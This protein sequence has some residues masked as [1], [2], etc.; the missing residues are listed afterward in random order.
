[1]K[2]IIH[3]VLKRADV[4][5]LDPVDAGWAGFSFARGNPD[6]TE[7]GWRLH[8]FSPSN[9]RFDGP[10]VVQVAGPMGLAEKIREGPPCDHSCPRHPPV[11]PEGY[12][13]VG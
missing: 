10:D 4:S 8:Y 12:Q 7:A 1:M 13:V 11:G 9:E 3:H 6:L 5:V 2:A